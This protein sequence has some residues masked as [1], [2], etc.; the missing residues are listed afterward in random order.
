MSLISIKIK[1]AGYEPGETKIQNLEFSI[2]KGELIGLIG[3]NGAG[4]STTIKSILGYIPF[5]EG[6]IRLKEGIATAYLPERPVFY[7]ELTLQ[8]HIHFIAA[9]EELPEEIVKARVTPLLEK[10]KLT[11][12]LHELPGTYS[13]GMQQKAMII[14][15]LMIKPDLLIIDEPFMGLDPIATKLLL[16]LILEESQRG[17]GILMCTHVLD[18]AEKVCDRFVLIDHGQQLALG[19]LEKFREICERPDGSLFECFHHLIEGKNH[20]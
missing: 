10:F 12:H 17:V 8:E 16:D 9:V 15:A 3:A 19:T 7:D 11:N 18:T 1:E 14:L 2:H 6:D 20:E 13:K 4:K 5:L